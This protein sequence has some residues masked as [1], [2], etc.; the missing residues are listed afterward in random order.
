M[1]CIAGVTD[2]T[3]VWIGGDS[4]AA[5]GYSYSIRAGELPTTLKG[6]GF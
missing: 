3:T 6:R 4:A 5:A 1:T 2:G